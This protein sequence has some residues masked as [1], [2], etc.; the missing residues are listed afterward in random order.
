MFQRHYELVVVALMETDSGFV[1]HIERT[2]QA[3]AKLRSEADP[4]RLAAGERVGFAVE[5]EVFDPNVEHK[6][7]ATR[8]FLDDD[9][10]NFLLFFAKFQALEKVHGLLNR[11]RRKIHNIRTGSRTIVLRG[12]FNGSQVHIERFWTQS[13]ASTYIARLIAEEI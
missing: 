10:R 11:E 2:Y 12:F 13:R 7:Q 8:D 9:M 3:A 1:E 4:L 6:L 5:G